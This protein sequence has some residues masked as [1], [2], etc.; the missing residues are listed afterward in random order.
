MGYY[1]DLS[2]FQVHM[3]SF[4]DEVAIIAGLEV[5]GKISEEG[6]YRLIKKAYR[7]LKENHKKAKNAGK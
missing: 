6:A 4:S 5:G 2:P 1:D 7:R 3:A